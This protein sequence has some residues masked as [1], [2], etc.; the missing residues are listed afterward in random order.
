MARVRR[1]SLGANPP[2]CLTD[3]QIETLVSENEVR[4]ER[5]VSHGHS[6]APGFWYD[7]PQ[8]EWVLVVAGHAALEIE[9]EAAPVELGAGDWIDLPARCRHRVLRTASDEPT[10]WLAVHIGVKR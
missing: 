9:G 7:Q 3:E 5:I 10:I 1:G 2:P 8:R 6:S 4:I